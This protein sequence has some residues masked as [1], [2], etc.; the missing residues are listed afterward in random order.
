MVP[1]IREP[2]VGSTSSREPSR[3][4]KSAGAEHKLAEYRGKRDPA[5]TAE[6]FEA[7]AEDT[8]GLFVVQKHA[9][10]RLHY[11]FRLAI[12]GVLVSW[13]VPKGPSYNPR[14]RR[15]AMHVEDHPLSYKDF[16]GTIPKGEYGG[17][18]VIVW[19][20]GPFRLREGSVAAGSLKVDLSGRKLVGGWALVRIRGRDATG[21]E[22]LLIKERDEHAD[23]DR[24]VAGEEPTSV[25]SGLT[26]EEVGK[27]K[28]AR[29]WNSRVLRAIESLSPGAA[30]RAAIP[31]ELSFMKARL[32]TSV[33][34][35]REWIYEIKLDG[36]R[37]LAI[38]SA[39][40]VRLVT[41]NA[42]EVAFRYPEVS[43]ALA[44]LQGGDFVMDGEIVAFDEQ[45]RSRFELLQGRI[46]LAEND[47]IAAAARSVPLFYHAFDLLHAEGHDLAGA[48]LV[49]RKAILQAWLETVDAPSCV[50]YSDHFE[51]D[52]KAF[53]AAACGRGLEGVIAKRRD[54]PYRGARTGDWV[55]LKCVGRQELVI[56]GFTPP[57]GARSHFGA[58]LVGVYA[59]NRLIYAGKVGT[60][61]DEATLTDLSRRLASIPR[62]DPPFVDPPRERGV[63]WVE[64]RLVAEVRFTEWTSDG[65]LR[66][67][68]FAGL[69][70]DK[71]PREC[72][73]EVPASESA[74]PKR[75]PSPA[76]RSA[77]P[78]RAQ[79]TPKHRAR[80]SA[81]RA[82]A[83]AAVRVGPPE[84]PITN[85]SKVFF[86]HAGVT[87]GDVIAYYRDQA[88]VIL[89]YLE[90]RPLTLVRFPN[91]ISGQSFFQKDQPDWLPEWIS[92][93][94]VPSENSRKKIVDYLVCNDAA[95]LTYVANLGTIDLHPW[96]S[97]QEA[98]ENPD[99][100][101]WDLDPPEDGYR[102][103]AEVAPRVR[104]ILER[105]ALT[106]FLKTSGGKGLHLYVPLVPDNDHD[107]VR[108][109]AELVAAMI[110]EANPRTTTL[111]RSK[112]ARR[113]KVY[114]DFLQNGRGKTVVAP[115]SLRA[116]EPA[117]VSMPLTWEEF[118]EGA[119]PADFTIRTVPGILAA[120][121]DVWRD[122]WKR[123]H[124]LGSVLERLGKP[125]ATTPKKRTS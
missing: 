84:V 97:R 60:G 110:V 12:G 23:P 106:P 96:A 119:Q 9:A 49:G 25:V 98:L 8:D 90:G 5:K 83:S 38:R 109:F 63:T 54:A 26:V 1:K 80:S 30:P 71:P 31:A 70:D 115:Y 88:D 116:K 107:T 120:R 37:A 81:R 48:P 65:K 61:F 94:S 7:A 59:G 78:K 79:P 114:V 55:K 13:A 33:P 99:Y 11:D 58:L 57:Q 20:R 118:D 27:R 41:R 91:G 113:G 75:P 4:G 44:A 47:R 104:E 112:A 93:V 69:R 85:P 15:L 122:L 3:R 36:V 56:G 67:P 42:K 105:A 87:K 72:V 19:D 125:S 52:G 89:P 28:D 46:H 108:S 102:K 39:D 86:P 24:D 73:R 22:W 21:K 82:P 117:T 111:E 124:R 100:V 16:E 77:R 121:G 29:Q 6:P 62:K 74:R 123:P 68:A 51:G 18:S 14:D 43:Q 101:V 53:L 17:G 2:G 35:G 64:P 66:H 50:R 45:G 92:T 40:E 95:T 103:A 10:S 32:E 76:P 34:A